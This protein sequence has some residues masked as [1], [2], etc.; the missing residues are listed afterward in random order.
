MLEVRAMSAKLIS[1]VAI[2]LLTLVNSGFGLGQ[3]RSADDLR[4]IEKVKAKISEIGSGYRVQI[5]L[6]DNSSMKGEI[7]VVAGDK[8]GL[9]DSKLRTVTPIRFDSVKSV[10][11]PGSQSSLLA[12]AYGAGIIGG[13]LAVTA[14]L[15]PRD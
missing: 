7:G 12:L 4:R 5:K 3:T 11:R 6:M 14:L 1:L 9:I 13:V 2:M 10:K 8:F 15:L